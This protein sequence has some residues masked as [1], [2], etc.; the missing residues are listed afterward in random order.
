MIE[1][2]PKYA[3]DLETLENESQLEFFRSSGPGGQN[4]NKRE[5]GVRLHH[6]LSGITIEVEEERSQWQNRKI[7]FERLQTRLAE[8]NRPVKKR[9]P[10]KIPRAEKR[11]RLEEKR[12]RSDLKELRKTSDLSL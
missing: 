11:K 7:A 10:T 8:L 9:M 12:R 2:Q 4:V 5:T 6:L 1:N 3:T